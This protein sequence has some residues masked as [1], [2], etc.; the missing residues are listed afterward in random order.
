MSKTAM[1]VMVGVALIGV[2]SFVAH[3]KRTAVNEQALV[4]PGTQNEIVIQATSGKKIP[5]SELVKKQDGA[6]KCT[7]NQYVANI[8]T[9]GT[10]YIN[11]GMIRGEF[12]TKVQNMNVD[13]TFVVR[14]GYSYTWSSMLPSMGFKAKVDTS[15]GGN[16]NT[17]GPSGTYVFNAEQIGDYNC[18]AWNVDQSKFQIPSN[19]T[20]KEMT[21]AGANTSAPKPRYDQW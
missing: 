21:A 4:Q 5:F 6:Y 9:K 16:N 12:N 2:G 18:E 20:F 15:A 10:A 1:W 7:V 11:A 8:E 17:A 14:D 19:I 3:G 13:S